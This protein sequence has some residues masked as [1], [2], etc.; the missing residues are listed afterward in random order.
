MRMR[1]TL[2]ALV[3]LLTGCLQRPGAAPDEAP[4]T[5]VL[6]WDRSSSEPPLLVN[7]APDVVTIGWIPSRAEAPDVKFRA[8]RHCEAW[9]RHAVPVRQY[10][11]GEQHF[12]EFACKDRPLEHAG[13]VT[14]AGQR[15][16]GPLRP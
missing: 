8:E 4:A 9:N 7:Q 14:S 16:T 1:F 6:R 3:L 5:V 2:L 11:I 15:E 10:V 13:A 12:A